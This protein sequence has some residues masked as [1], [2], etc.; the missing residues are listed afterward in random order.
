MWK[1]N[2]I[3]SFRKTTY[4]R[5]KGFSPIRARVLL[6]LF[7]YFPF[8]I[9]YSVTGQCAGTKIPS[10]GR[11]FYDSHGVFKVVISVPNDSSLLLL[12]L[13]RYNPAL[14]RRGIMRACRKQNTIRK[15]HVT[16][17]AKSNSQTRVGILRSCA[18]T[19]RWGYFLTRRYRHTQC[20]AR[21]N[22]SIATIRINHPSDWQNFFNSTLPGHE[23]FIL[24]DSWNFK[25][26]DL[27]WGPKNVH[28]NQY[29]NIN[30]YSCIQSKRESLI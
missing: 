30:I 8:N 16:Y 6:L 23:M 18:S 27:Q 22:K 25:R 24:N 19:S 15:K 21:T 10:V 3:T 14:N 17:V 5:E 1:T 4:P 9:L 28:S 11:A 20:T 12:L 7:F 29:N 2:V 26:S 13:H